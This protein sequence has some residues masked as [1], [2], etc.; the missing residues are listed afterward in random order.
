MRSCLFFLFALAL[1]STPIEAVTA[2]SIEVAEPVVTEHRVRIQG[3]NIR[4]RAVAGDTLL[5]NDAGEPIATIY[6]TAYFRTD[7]R[8]Q[9]QR[10]ITFVFNGGPGSS[11][12]WLHLGLYGPKK[13]LVPSDAENPGAAPYEFKDNPHSLL[14]LTDLVFIDPVGTGY[15]RAVGAGKNSDFWGVRQDAQSLAE[16]IRLFVTE[17]NRWNAPKYL[18]GESYGTARVGALL[19]E[20][21]EGWGSMTING[22]H[23]ISSIVDF[24]TTRTSPGND[25]PYVF[26]L[27]TYAATAWYHDALPN[28]PEALEPF[29]DE[30]REFATSELHVALLRGSRISDT[31]YA[32]VVERMAYFTGLSETYIRQS[33]LRVQPH[34]FFRE[35]LRD[36]DQVVGRLDSRFIGLESEHVNERPVADP[37]GYGIDGAYTAAINYHL[38]NN[39][40]VQRTDEYHILSGR[41]FSG[42]DWSAPPGQ[43]QGYH[44][45][46]PHFATAQQRNKDF[47]I[48]IANGY[49][50]AATPF[51]ATEHSFNNNGIDPSRVEMKYYEAGH[52][53]YIH[54]PSLAQLAF[55]LR[56]FYQN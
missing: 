25:L 53:M 56:A 2:G 36:R 16:F 38:R 15:S 50:D 1:G 8:D 31:D 42:W 19:R 35:L 21:Q 48:F 49:Y 23:L 27:P 40:N 10:P 45:L 47:R 39:L 43:Q 33:N 4:Y 28:R 26:Y 20:L 7:V 9:E 12:V 6:S 44:N 46:A 37:S 52:M 18:A 5:K 30:A 29:L 17:H 14:D 55:D 11:S 13:V 51:F 34:R 3:N 24:R 32:S 41:V 54:H 22:V